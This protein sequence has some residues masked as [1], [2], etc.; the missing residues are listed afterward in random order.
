MTGHT[1]VVEYLQELLGR[2]LKDKPV[3]AAYLYGSA[4]RGETTPLSD[5]DIGLLIRSPLSLLEKLDL[6]LAV[7][8]ELASLGCG[9]SEVRVVNEAPIALRGELVTEGILLYSADESERV[10]FETRARGEYF[11]FLPCLELIRAHYL[12]TSFEELDGKRHDRG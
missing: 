3:A 4:A 5:V 1:E 7:E 9:R 11:D 10:D 6:E 12:R 8:V 2:V